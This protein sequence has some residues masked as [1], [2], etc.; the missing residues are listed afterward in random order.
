M[1]RLVKGVVIMP[2]IAQPY[3]YVHRPFDIIG[4]APLVA[5]SGFN[6]T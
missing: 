3:G 1:I 4:A 6:M 2:L 5:T